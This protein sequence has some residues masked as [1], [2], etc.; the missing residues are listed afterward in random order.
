METTVIKLSEMVAPAFK[1]FWHNTSYYKILK[2]GRSSTKSS[3][4]SLKLVLDFL[5]D[6]KANVVCFRKVAKYIS[7]SV[8]EQIKWAIYQLHVENEFT[9]LTAPQ[10]IIHKATKSAF[11]FFGV[12]DPVKIKSAKIAVGYVIA[13]WFEEASE[14]EDLKEIDTVS[15]TFIR[16]DLP[17][18]KHVDVYFSYNPPR[19][20][21][22][23]INEWEEDVRHNKDYFIHESDYESEGVANFLSKQFIEKVEAVKIKD[24]DYWRWMYKGEKIGLGNTVYNYN[25]FNEVNTIPDD[26]RLLFADIAIDSGYSVSATTFLYLGYTVKQRVILLDTYY[27]SPVDQLKKKAPS[28]FSKDL[29]DF[30]KHNYEK[31]SLNLDTQTIDSAEGAL[32]NQYDKDYSVYLQPAKKKPKVK[33]IE[34]VEDLLVQDRVFVLK[35]KNNLIFLDEHKKY[36]WDEKTLNTAD[37]KV[38]KEHDHTCDAFQYY[39]NNNLSK[40]GLK[41]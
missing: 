10:R 31:Y 40:L 4:I 5:E 11:Y 28:D 18:D 6:D 38:V 41:M 26:D 20:P 19:N 24:Y 36:Q 23:W 34:N 12:D 30:V 8:Y 7:T 27:Y 22:V 33:M 37:P 3:N 14:F 17:D 29:N 15:D 13:L 1:D 2:G 39:V 16:E 21:Y 25:L 35:T 9:F 32:R